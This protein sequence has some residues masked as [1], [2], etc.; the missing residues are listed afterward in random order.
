MVKLIKGTE[1]KYLSRN[2]E[3]FKKNLLDHIA[4]NKSLDSI[5]SRYNHHEVKSSLIKE[6]NGKCMYCE[7]KVDHVAYLHIDHIKPKSRAP[8]LTFEYSNM[9]VACPVCNQEKSNKYDEN[10]P[11]VNPY[12]DD[13]NGFFESFGG[14]IRVKNERAKQ[15]ELTV[16]LNRPQLLEA[17]RERL[18]LIR[19]L[20]VLYKSVNEPNKSV[21]KAEILR[22]IDV[23]NAYSFCC[24]GLFEYLEST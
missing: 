18:H 14:I 22:Q 13:P 23:K 6:T 15:T 1:P 11:I 24:R 5:V 19:S 3:R 17:R 21:L 12:I 9:G 2:K 4:S 16:K 8:E 10:N 20:Y 7:S